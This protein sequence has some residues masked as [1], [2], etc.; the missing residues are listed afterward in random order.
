MNAQKRHTQKTFLTFI[1]LIV[2]WNTMKTIKNSR[3]MPHANIPEAV[4]VTLLM[5]R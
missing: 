4:N 2:Y 1:F 3:L 5:L